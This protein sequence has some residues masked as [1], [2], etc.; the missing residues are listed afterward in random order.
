MN[1]DIEN[2]IPAK[3]SVPTSIAKRSI[4]KGMDSTITIEQKSMDKLNFNVDLV[5]SDEAD[6]KKEVQKSD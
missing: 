4:T 5:D 2:D 6:E 1:I 3:I